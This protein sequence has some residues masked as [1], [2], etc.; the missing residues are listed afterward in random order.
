MAE[1]GEKRAN[2]ASLSS[3]RGGAGSE[4]VADDGPKTGTAAAVGVKGRRCSCEEDDGEGGEDMSLQDKTVLA[5]ST[6]LAL[7]KESL[8][9]GVGGGGARGSG[10]DRRA[11][12]AAAKCR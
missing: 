4:A 3:G 7:E 1:R 9:P 2:G 12:I 11:E 5:L 10:G 8:P 6:R